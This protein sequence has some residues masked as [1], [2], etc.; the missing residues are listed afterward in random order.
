M[1][2]LYTIDGAHITLIR[3]GTV[4]LTQVAEMGQEGMGT[5]GIDD[6]AGTLSVVGHK[7]VAITQSSC[8]NTRT[9]SGFVDDREYERGSERAPDVGAGR[10]ITVQLVDLNNYLSQT[11]ITGT[12]GN[13][14][15][16]G[17]TVNERLEWLFNS[18]YWPAEVAT[19]SRVASSTTEL[20]KADYRQQQPGDV[21]SD[22]STATGW[23][24]YVADW[25][26]GPELTFRDDNASTADTS[27]IRIS[28]VSTDVDSDHTTLGAGKTFAPSMDFKLSRSPR[29]VYSKMSLSYGKG[30]RTD[31]RAATATAFN[32]ERY[33]TASTS[34]IKTA[35]LAD[36]ELE[37]LLHVH[38]TETDF[39]EGSILVPASAVNLLRQGERL[40]VKF[41]HLAT[42][43]YGSFT[44]CRVMER[45]VKPLNAEGAIYELRLRLSPQ[46]AGPVSDDCTDLY[47]ETS[48]GNY[49]PLGGNP[50]G[51]G[52][53]PN[54]SDGV[55]YYYRGG[56]E[57]PSV[58]DPGLQGGWHFSSL[59]AG[60]VGTIDYAGDNS[61]NV[62]VFMSVGNGEWVIQ[63]EMWES[64][65]R[66]IH[67]AVGPTFETAAFVEATVSGAQITVTIADATDGDCIRLVKIYD[68]PPDPPGFDKWGW[69]V[70]EWTGA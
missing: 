38:S 29:E 28:N 18:D 45:T 58:P 59:G 3:D 16:G 47:A 31:E 53:P 41:S 49:Y 4:E 1:G 22:I 24:Y 62:L 63:T 23:N 34:N 39:L 60:G 7:D 66:T 56:L 21:L 2:E 6:T 11:G 37:R 5:L 55:V 36:D 54:P 9:Y 64:R 30:T 69:S 26:S 10:W 51:S 35:A 61:S 65:A 46:E 33:G 68:Q 13:R 44:W 67:V 57:V 12:D 43:G 19:G 70:A 25:G 52:T 50:P 42:E 48:D 20:D 27:D 14:K 40:Q 32:G 8:A 15:D 17:E